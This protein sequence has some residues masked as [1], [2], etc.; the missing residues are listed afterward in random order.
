[1]MESMI[2]PGFWAGRR[3]FLTGHTG[4][5]GSWMALALHALG[6]EVHGFAL[7]P[8]AGPN[9]FDLT[10]A[11]GALAGEIRADIRDGEALSAALAAA[12]P[13]IVIHMAAQAI[14]AEGYRDPVGTFGT[15]VMGTLHLLEGALAC[16]GV[17][18]IV[19]VTSDKVYRN[20]GAGRPFVE[21]DPL[22]GSDPYSASKAAAELAVAA[23]RTGRAG[24]PT[25][26]VRAGNVIGGG[27]FAPARIIPDLARALA[28][29]SEL[30]V[31]NPD[32][33]R[34]FQHVTDVLRGYLLAAQT[35]VRRPGDVPPALNFGPREREISIVELLEAW[36]AATGRPVDWTHQPRPDL[37]ESPRLALDSSRAGQVL[38]W[39][40]AYG[41]AAAVAETAAWYDGWLAGRDMPALSRAAIARALGLPT[42]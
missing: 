33:T 10:G 12:R 29:R 7:A 37:P 38:G 34:P 4:F 14:V 36:Q 13:S 17:E 20:Q 35:L 16:G 22:G 19:I 15:N 42:A 40:P 21:D 23:W 18:A 28:E 39:E 8:L 32:A 6:A 5:K 25:L 9:P 2:E 11:A 26:C 41:T 3:V 24:P 31:R 1:M 27:D 30:A